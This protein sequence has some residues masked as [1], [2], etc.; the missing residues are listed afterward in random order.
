MSNHRTA[1]AGKEPRLAPYL[2]D[3]EQIGAAAEHIMELH[4]TAGIDKAVAIGGYIFGRF[5][6][7]SIEEWQSR[8]KNKNNSLDRIAA[9]PDCT[10]KKPTL[11]RYV[12]VYVAVRA[13]PCVSELKHVTAKHIAT[14]ASLPPE[15]QLQ[16]LHCVSA[17]RW[18]VEQ[19]QKQLTELRRAAGDNRGRRSDPAV[20]RAKSAL[21]TAVGRLKR[22]VN[23]VCELEMDD[24]DPDIQE[25]YEAVQSLASALRE[26]QAKPRSGPRATLAL[27]EHAGGLSDVG[28]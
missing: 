2:E 17:A 28:N 14:V 12:R 22:A 24:D 18:S 1:T 19:L 7:G 5:Y 11:H 15:G 6:G 27:V 8:E 26:H 20:K 4:R 21:R 23:G 25:L 10:L 13:Q 16:W 9:H 3:P